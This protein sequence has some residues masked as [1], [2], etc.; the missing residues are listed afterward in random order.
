M[1]A[2]DLM[3]DN[4]KI[5]KNARGLHFSGPV[6]PDHSGGEL[7][8]RECRDGLRAQRAVPYPG[9]ARRHGAV[10]RA[11]GR[12]GSGSAR[13][14][15]APARRRIR[16]RC[17]HGGR[18]DLG[19][20]CAARAGACFGGRVSAVRVCRFRSSIRRLRAGAWW[21]AWSLR[22]SSGLSSTRSCFCGLPLARSNS[23]SARS[24]A[25]SGWCCSR[26]RSSPGSGG[27]TSGLA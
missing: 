11:D 23:C 14:G 2:E 22:A 12:R 18:R 13:P 20:P 16:H 4:D 6:L 19:R 7:D 17:D 9:R 25:S 8:D 5:A 21:Q 24:S 1:R 27:A 10:G 15:A 3:I 26:F